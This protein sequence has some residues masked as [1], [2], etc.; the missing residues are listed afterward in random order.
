MEGAGLGHSHGETRGAMHRAGRGVQTEG[1]GGTL[2]SRDSAG[3][4]RLLRATWPPSWDRHDCGQGRAFPEAPRPESSH[5]QTSH[6][7]CFRVQPLP[8]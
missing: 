4:N 8:D 2:T 3:G 5:V 1:E 6:Q 7:L